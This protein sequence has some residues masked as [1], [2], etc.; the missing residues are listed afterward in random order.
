MQK[1]PV[2]QKLQAGKCAYGTS[3]SGCL[4]PEVA[5]TLGSAG[6]DFFFIDTE[7]GPASYAAI[8][9]LCR[10]ARATGIVPLVRVPDNQPH[11]ISRALD[12][13]AMGIIVPRVHSPQAAKAVIEVAKFPPLGHRG[14]GLG[15]IV[16]DLRSGP[17]SEEVESCNRE[18]LVVVQIESREALA[19]V[20]E[21]ACLD[22]LDV[23]FIGPYDLT[24]SLGIIEQFD[25][26]I[27][28]S[29]VDKTVE[30]CEK[31]RKAA[32]IQ[33]AN[34][35]VLRE[36]QRRGVRFLMYAHDM[37]VLWTGYKQAVAELAG[38]TN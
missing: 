1:N 33:L 8:G 30:A 34:M 31:T 29:A 14:F 36:S 16:T 27:F 25:N 17:A 35:D 28:W 20:Q 12:L 11:L 22:G 6:L 10:S 5:V 15:S 24:L 37:R 13:G 19:C 4:D 38:K 26:P 21:I 18:T 7:H 9:G 23:L 32:G 3:L 2:K